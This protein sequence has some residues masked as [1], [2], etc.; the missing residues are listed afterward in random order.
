MK[1][2]APLCG[3]SLIAVTLVTLPAATLRMPLDEV[4][5]GMRGTGITVFDGT[6]RE[7]FQVH[8]LGVLANVMGPRRTLIVAR[9]E[10]GPLADTGVIQGMSGSP[11]YI[12]D[13]LVGAVSYSLGSFSKE[14]IAGITPI[15]EMAA[16]DAAPVLAAQHRSP[17][18]Q[19]AATRHGLTDVVRQAFEPTQPFARRPVDIRADG[20]PASEAGRLGTL[21]RPIGTPLVLNG[22]V[23]EIHDLWAAAFDGSGFVTTIGGAAVGAE[24]QAAD[25]APLAP[26]DPLGASLITGDMTMAGTGTVT[27]VE[28][29]RVYAFGHPFYNLGHAQFPMTR[30]HVTTLLPSLAI[31]SKIAAIG[32]VIGTIDQDRATGIYGSLGPGP[33]LVPVSVT[34]QAG[35][36]DLRERFDFEVI[37]DPLF[38]PLLAYTGILN[39]FFSWTREVGAST[40][41]IAGT[42]QLS[43]HADVTFRDVFAGD[44]AG[45]NAAVSVSTPLTTLLRNTFEPV[46]VERVDITITS[47]EE[48]RTATLERVWVDAV[49]PRAGDV[50]PIKVASRTARGTETVET[51]MVTLPPH[52][53]GPV[54]I[55]VSAA[56]ELR[57]REALN[58]NQPHQARTLE[59]LI[60]ALNATRGNDRLYI[61]LLAAR[62]GAV[63][64]GEA[65]SALPASVLAVLEGNRAGGGLVRLQEATLG[66]WEL[67]TEHVVTGSRLLSL[68][69]EAG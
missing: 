44:A 8:I 39:T 36:R 61:K 67:P 1:T 3:A 28:N 65:L 58:G 66:E 15:D 13:R 51:V 14:A 34:L 57:Q 60:R 26:G 4:R 30:A 27:M 68:S 18:I 33:A 21:L 56:A 16:T 54:Q 50:I 12:D 2:L 42:V 59:Q 41:E 53:T 62:P 35:D 52:I 38:T 47:Y 17:P 31:S 32:E 20:L 43:G 40:Y 69:V 48:P 29:G 6:T 49:R 9:L 7:Q 55:L 63:V 10:G 64:R 11:V 25:P 19:L 23:P 22:F 5:T 37:D 46:E 24:M 45:I